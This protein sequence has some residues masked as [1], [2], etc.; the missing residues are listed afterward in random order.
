MW[1]S[2]LCYDLYVELVRAFP[3]SA[4]VPK[5]LKLLL[6]ISV[7]NLLGS[8]EVVRLINKYFPK[9]LEGETNRNPEETDKYFPSEF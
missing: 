4:Q 9:T 1:N 5:F 6:C 2:D 8:G 7:D 3:I